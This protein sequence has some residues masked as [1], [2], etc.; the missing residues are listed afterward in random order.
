MALTLTDFDENAGRLAPVWSN[1]AQH[2]SLLEEIEPFGR[3]GS[4]LN[5]FTRKATQ[6]EKN[7]TGHVPVVS[8]GQGWQPG[9]SK[10]NGKYAEMRTS[11]FW[12]TASGTA[13]LAGAHQFR[14]SCVAFTSVPPLLVP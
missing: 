14:P 11:R 2:V 7:V 12:F 6:D 8:F 3:I 13:E 10:Q 1:I 4:E 5:Q 9:P